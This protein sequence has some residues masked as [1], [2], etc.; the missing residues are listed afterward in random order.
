MLKKIIL[1]ILAIALLILLTLGGIILYAQLTDYKPQEKEQ[2]KVVGENKAQLD[3]DSLSLMIWNIG[4][5][6]LGA[7]VDFFYDGGDNVITPK[8]LVSKYY[9]GIEQT[10]QQY[11][12]TDFVLLQEVDVQ[13][14]RSHKVNQF[15]GLGKLNPKWNKAF[16]KNYDVNF[17]PLPF[18]SPM[19]SVIGGLATYTPY[20]STENTRYQFPGNYEWPKALFFLDRC[21]LLQRF[22]AKNGKELVVI[23]THNS[24]Y[25]DGS[26]KKGQMDYLKN[27]LTEEYE[28]GNYVIVGGDWNQ[29]PPGFD[30]NKFVKPGGES[31]YEQTP[32]TFDYMPDWLWAYDPNTP[33]NRKVSYPYDKNKTF[34]T[35]IDFFLLSPNVKL[36]KIQGKHLDFQFSDHQPVYMEVVLN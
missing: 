12:N 14:K 18:S 32:I 27:V 5:S 29:T 1:F 11:K 23:N 25:D 33:T 13:S 4:Y 36:S 21:F 10:V 30:N 3:S 17:V 28:K 15:E 22:P 9:T 6:G 2:V 7:D 26:L 16:G 24:A 35:V 20:Q 31:A 8:E 34:T 19:G